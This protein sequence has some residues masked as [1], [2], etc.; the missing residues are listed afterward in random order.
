MMNNLRGLVSLAAVVLVS[1]AYAQTTDS[2]RDRLE[3]RF[4]ELQA[5]SGA[6]GATAAIVLADGRTLTLA[7]GFADSARRIVMTSQHRMH[8]GS[9][10]KTFVAAVIMQLLS[11][12]RLGL[13]EHIIRWF[14]RERWFARFPTARN[15]TVR[16]LLNHSGGVPDHVRLRTFVNAVLISSPDRVWK[17][18]EILGYLADAKPV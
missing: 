8:G 13:D 11:E 9:T 10:G 1:P 7:A 14:S 3:A 2:L 6:P 18:A 5:N 4:T 16:M 12:G 17:P 15:I